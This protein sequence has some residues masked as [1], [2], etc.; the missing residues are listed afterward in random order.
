[1]PDPSRSSNQIGKQKTATVTRVYAK[2]GEVCEL[3]PG[4]ASNQIGQLKK[5]LS[6]KF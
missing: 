2:L 4:N 6:A 1:V 3:D 5:P